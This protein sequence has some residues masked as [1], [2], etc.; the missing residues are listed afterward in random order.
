ML[1]DKFCKFVENNL[2]N[3]VDRI[4]T[5]GLFI[6]DKK[7][8]EIL[9]NKFENIEE[10]NKNF[11]L[12]FNTTVIEDPEGLFIITDYDQ[13]NQ[14]GIFCERYFIDFTRFFIPELMSTAN[15]DDIAFAINLLT[16]GNYSKIQHKVNI[17]DLYTMSIGS[18]IVI[19]S[20]NDSIGVKVNTT[21]SLLVTKKDVICGI[22]DVNLTKKQIE[23]NLIIGLKQILL[24]N[25]PNYFIV[26]ESPVK[27]AK[28]INKNKIARSHQRPKYTVLK[29]NKI[30][31]LFKYT[32]EEITENSNKKSPTP[33]LRR[34]HIR[35]FRSDRYI[36]A[37]NKQIIIPATWIGPTEYYDGFKK[38]RVCLEK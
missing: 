3:Y 30:H 5:S 7:A 12:P 18:V 28:K 22:P 16:D 27:T 38:Y 37:K 17:K 11:F 23:S 32:P 26:E 8:T 25:S 33:H 14:I 20:N 29:P 2:P 9:P 24:I 34:R 15:P 13:P 1:F 36:N 10:L 6:F 4:K 35:T 19:E 31:K 21:N